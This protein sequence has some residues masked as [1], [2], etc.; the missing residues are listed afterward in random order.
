LIWGRAA[1]RV[2]RLEG[3]ALISWWL[4]LG[5]QFI[6]PV[7][8]KWCSLLQLTFS[9]PMDFKNS[10]F[11]KQDSIIGVFDHSIILK[12]NFNS[13]FIFVITKKML[14]LFDNIK[15]RRNP[16]SPVLE[17]HKQWKKTYNATRIS[18]IKTGWLWNLGL[19]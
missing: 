5:K 18:L 10:A 2:V 7:E 3:Q 12:E 13:K 11:K 8:N 16:N 19:Q 14:Q 6:Q 17:R 4:G 1:P 9:F 15:Y